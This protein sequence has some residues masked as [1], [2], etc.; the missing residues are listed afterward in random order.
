MRNFKKSKNEFKYVYLLTPQG[1]VEKVAL[2]SRFLK[3]KMDEYD[4]LKVEIEALKAEAGEDPGHGPEA[5]K[6][7]T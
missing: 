6:Q 3:R 5:L 1:I 7:T 4:A 2:T